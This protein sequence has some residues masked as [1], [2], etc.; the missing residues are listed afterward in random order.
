MLELLSDEKAWEEFLKY[1]QEKNLLSKNEVK[2]LTEFIKNKE[3]LEIST[4]INDGSYSF[5]IPTKI[6]ISKMATKKKRIVYSYSYAENNILKLLTYLLYKYDDEL[7]PNC[8][9]FRRKISS[10]EA[11]AKLAKENRDKN[12]ACFKTDISNYFNSIDTVI[13]EDTIREVIKDDDELINLLL[14]VVKDDRCIWH[15]EVIHEHKGAMAGTPI[16]P[17]LRMYIYAI[18]INIFMR[19]IYVTLDTQ[20]M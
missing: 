3:Y 4:K 19:M 2:S 5:S 8:Y 17:F 15:G 9:A 6:I 10:K 11:F 18:W 13:L 1:K 20:M 7:Y 16:S 14:S 12:Y